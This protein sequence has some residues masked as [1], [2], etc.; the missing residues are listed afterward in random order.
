MQVSLSTQK[1]KQ[2]VKKIGLT[3]VLVS[4]IKTVQHSDKILAM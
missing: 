4:S 2:V 3:E 1:G